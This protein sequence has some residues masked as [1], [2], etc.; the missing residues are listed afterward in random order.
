MS[1]DPTY[2]F[3]TGPEHDAL[4]TFCG[5]W[6][7][8]G[9]LWLD[10]SAAP[11][12]ATWEV[13]ATALFGGRFVRFAY[14]HSVGGTPHAG[15]LTLAYE[16][17]EKRYT[18]AWIDSFHTGT[19]LLVSHGEADDAGIVV[20]G[21]YPAGPERWGWR[22]RVAREGEGLVITMWNITPAGEAFPAVE[23]RLARVGG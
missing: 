9:A 19:M 13:R 20:L 7:G 11:D 10:P 16:R 21:S 17:D 5:E 18:A 3:S 15:E 2:D 8:E 12:R 6:R 23:V 1:C 14:T 22:T 4:A